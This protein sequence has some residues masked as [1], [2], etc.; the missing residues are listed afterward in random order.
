[1]ILNNIACCSFAMGNGVAALLTINEA[2]DLQKE[3]NENSSAKADLDLLH[4]AIL[5]NNSGYLRVSVKQ[6]D[7]A[8]SCFEEALLVSN[9][10]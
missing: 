8:R 9:L 7:E 1:M 10:V 2:S 5:L 6:Y 3:R 4:M